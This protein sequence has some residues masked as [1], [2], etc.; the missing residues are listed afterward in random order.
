MS[1]QKTL[2]LGIATTYRWKDV[3]H[4]VISLRQTGFDG[5]IA[6]LVERKWLQ[7]ND[8]DQFRRYDV[9][10]VEVFSILSR[11]PERIRRLR[12][13]RPALSIQGK[14]SFFMAQML[15]G[16]CNHP[17]LNL[18]QTWF[19]PV[20]S[21]RFFIYRN[22]I[23]DIGRSYSHVV[24]SDVRDVIFQRDPGRWPSEASINFFLE[25]PRATVANEPTNARWIN[26]MYGHE[27][28][29][30][31]G[32]A[33][34]SC[35]GV[36]H[37]TR[38]GITE[39]LREMTHELARQTAAISGENGF[40]QGVHNFLLHDGKFPT[41][42]VWENGEGL[43]LNM[44]G[45]RPDEWRVTDDGTVCIPS[46]TVVPVIHQYDRHPNLKESIVRKFHN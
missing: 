16:S 19:H 15:G 14:A 38:A 7:E 2:V 26:H 35:A 30:R 39:Y 34:V 42:A 32:T 17:W 5:D 33:R 44:Q 3:S 29:E 9:R 31:I 11:I 18:A 4:F 22:L 40:D 1:T 36:L 6:L 27:A 10:L 41:A 46:G 8:Y 28:L 37:A 43:A 25:S 20:M 21:A 45:L 23:E 13:S 12:F 24:L